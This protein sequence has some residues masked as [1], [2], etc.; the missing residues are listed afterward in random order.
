MLKVLYDVAAF[1][2]SYILKLLGVKV[3][4]MSQVDQMGV[5]KVMEETCDYLSARWAKAVLC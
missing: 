2:F 4:S 5:A 1:Y 3:Y